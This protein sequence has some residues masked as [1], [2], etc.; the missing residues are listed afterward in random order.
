[1]YSVS[2]DIAEKVSDLLMDL[3]FQG[4]NRFLDSIPNVAKRAEDL[5]NL[6]SKGLLHA[7]DYGKYQNELRELYNTKGEVSQDELQSLRKKFD[8]GLRTLAVADTDVNDF[9]KILDQ[10]GVLYAK[11]NLEHKDYHFF[12]Y[13]EEY[14]PEVL[15]AT[16]VLEAKRGLVT[17]LPAD[18]YVSTLAPDEITLMR[19]LDKEKLELFRHFAREEGLLFSVLPEDNEHRYVMFAK[20]DKVKAENAMLKVGWTLTGRHGGE[21]YEQLRTRVKMRETL[22]DG[23]RD[24]QKFLCVVSTK[25]PENRIELNEEGFTVFKGKNLVLKKERSEEDFEDALLRQVEGLS[26]PALFTQEE[27]LKLDLNDRDSV[28]EKSRHKSMALFT[29]NYHEVIEMNSLAEF[30]N[31][32]SS[33]IVVQELEGGADHDYTFGITS[34]DM[35]LSGFA[36]SEYITAD[37]EEIEARKLALEHF[38]EA[39]LYRRENHE[40]TDVNTNV[41]DLDYIISQAEAKRERRTMEEPVRSKAKEQSNDEREERTSPF[42][43]EK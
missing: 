13:P 1:M 3:F 22:L 12:S 8:L 41:K 25:W 34:P 18:L 27:F 32:V 15:E 26:E 35:D 24:P 10:R 11:V 6:T 4:G 42:D 37:E 17:E 39:A 36:H 2:D 9:A 5:K 14:M 28:K 30:K 43:F 23:I 7:I 21:M 40:M 19:G 29:E 16:K 33:K 38:K 20:E 31:I